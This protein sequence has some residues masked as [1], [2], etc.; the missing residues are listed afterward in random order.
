MTKRIL[1]CLAALSVVIGLSA[2]G[3]QSSTMNAAPQPVVKPSLQGNFALKGDL[4]VSV[5]FSNG[6]WT[7]QSSDDSSD[8]DS[9]PL[10]GLY[11]FANKPARDGNPIITLNRQVDS[12]TIPSAKTCSTSNQKQCIF[13]ERTNWQKNV[14]CGTI[15]RPDA[16]GKLQRVLIGPDN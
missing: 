5:S 7:S 9:S 4:S 13:K 2:C 16:T 10:H 6:V 14:K 8:G 1:T 12:K 11:E 15:F 3:G